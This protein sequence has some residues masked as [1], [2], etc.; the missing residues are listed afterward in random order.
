MPELSAT[1]KR[2][3]KRRVSENAQSNPAF[4]PFT[5]EDKP[6][7]GAHFPSPTL[8]PASRAALHLGAPNFNLPLPID[9]TEHM[10]IDDN[11]RN[12]DEYPLANVEIVKPLDPHP[13]LHHL[14]Q[15]AH[16]FDHLP[17][18]Q[19]YYALLY[20][21]R[22][23][24]PTTLQRIGNVIVTTI[25]RDFITLLPQEIAYHVL[26]Y[27]DLK[28]LS[29]STS[30]CK[31]WHS[32]LAGKLADSLWKR[33]LQGRGWYSQSEVTALRPMKLHSMY[34]N[35]YRRHHILADNWENGL[36]EHMVFPGHDTNVV[37]CL[38]FDDDKIVSGSDD[39]TMCVFDVK[40]GY[41]RKTLQGHEGGVWALQYVG[42]T[43]VSG[44]TDRTVRVWD[45]E[46]GVCT[47]SFG[48]HTSTVRCLIILNPVSTDGEMEPS[49][50]LIVSGSRDGTL[51]VWLLPDIKF[52]RSHHDMID[53]GEII[54]NGNPYFQHLLT[55]HSSSVRAI[56]GHGKI[57]VSGSY[58]S[59]VRVWNVVTG[60][61][62]HHLRGH[63]DRVYCVGYDSET[64]RAASGSMDTTVRVWDTVSGECLH[65]LEGLL[66]FRG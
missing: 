10:D 45:L 20:L 30:V 17:D 54:P 44:S 65:V 8:S 57:V 15:I 25:K 41:L 43:L 3:S 55:G 14:P 24:P 11:V 12:S 21:L 59:S 39:M 31:D 4:R 27:L 28:S 26:G 56:V 2:G 1:G 34:K 60:E 5:T 6:E 66:S 49:T 16:T 13:W 32:L 52:D 64:K 40:T 46:T 36:Y 63:R 47:H 37:T 38:Q 23:C 7:T 33:M 9:R 18:E 22:R 50:P 62:V 29:I 48:G 42:D 35:I 61:C 58:D 53:E 51:R 19:K